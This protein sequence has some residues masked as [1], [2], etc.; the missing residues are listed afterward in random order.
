MQ[1]NIIEYQTV[2]QPSLAWTKNKK[3]E[4]LKKIPINCTFMERSIQLDTGMGA[5]IY[6]IIQYGTVDGWCKITNGNGRRG[7]ED[8]GE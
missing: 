2:P 4:L 1:E 3:R 7:D 5:K 6:I 8:S